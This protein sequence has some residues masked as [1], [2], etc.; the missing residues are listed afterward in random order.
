MK[1]CLATSTGNRVTMSDDTSWIGTGGS[2]SGMLDNGDTLWFSV[3]VNPH[4]TGTNPDFGFALST[5]Q[6]RD[7][8][9]VP[10]SNSGNGMGFRVKRGLRATIWNGGPASS[11]TQLSIAAGTVH[12]VV[13]EMIFG[14]GTDTIN[15][16]LPDTDLN[17]GAVVRSQTGDVDQTQFDTITFMNKAANPRDQVDEIRFGATA[18]DVLPSNITAIPEPSSA[19]LLSI[20]GTLALLRRR[21]N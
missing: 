15:L 5:D 3:L 2:L 17:L 18:A 13:G 9:N 21:K 7:V 10:L 14:A 1:G 11:S 20:F 8:N 6:G 4:S 16:Y 19:A 12:L